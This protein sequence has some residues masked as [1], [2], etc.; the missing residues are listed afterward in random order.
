MNALVDELKQALDILEMRAVE[1]E[2][3]NED[4]NP[5]VALAKQQ[6]E[7]LEAKRKKMIA[8]EQASKKGGKTEKKAAGAKGKQ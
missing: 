7:K 1:K 5:Y 8:A 2:A 3:E 6:A 4:E